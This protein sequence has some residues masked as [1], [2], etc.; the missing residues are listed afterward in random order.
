MGNVIVILIL[1]QIMLKFTIKPCF[2]WWHVL[3][4][5]VYD[6][7]V[8]D[9]GVSEHSY[10]TCGNQEI[11][12]YIHSNKET[13]FYVVF[14]IGGNSLFM[15][16]R[17]IWFSWRLWLWKEIFME[18][19]IKMWKG[20]ASLRVIKSPFPWCLQTLTCKSCLTESLVLS[21]GAEWGDVLWLLSFHLRFVSWPNF[22]VPSS[23]LH[24][25]PFPSSSLTSCP[26]CEGG[27]CFSP[28]WGCCEGQCFASLWCPQMSEE[29]RQ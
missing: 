6:S 26:W 28:T 16:H 14:L 21:S 15:C 12:C 1:F 4:R 8:F 19:F 25:T 2:S 24:Q 20:G 13:K 29:P 9:F 17:E 5:T 10:M 11:R 27:E 23:R 22:S 7:Y 3:K 18:I